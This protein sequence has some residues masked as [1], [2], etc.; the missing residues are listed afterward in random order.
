MQEERQNWMKT[1][2][3]KRIKFKK[4]KKKLNKKW[5]YVNVTER[6][7]DGIKDTI[8]SKR[9]ERTVIFIMSESGRRLLLNREEFP[10]SHIQFVT[11][12]L[13]SPSQTAY[14]SV[15][16]LQPLRFGSTKTTTK[17]KPIFISLLTLRRARTTRSVQ[18]Y[19]YSQIWRYVCIIILYVRTPKKIGVE[20][21]K[22][23]NNF[24]YIFI[25]IINHVLWSQ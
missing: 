23:K 21:K 16:D 6:R 12:R 9:K 11:C 22:D 20:K 3:E 19:T 2:K 25:A 8:D 15:Q 24:V 14:C 5:N 4:E 10:H 17:R 13:E 18:T 7:R 1:E